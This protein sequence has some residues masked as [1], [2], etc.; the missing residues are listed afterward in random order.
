MDPQVIQGRA[1]HRGMQ[2][3][4]HFAMAFRTLNLVR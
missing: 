3:G 2:I 1:A 4:V